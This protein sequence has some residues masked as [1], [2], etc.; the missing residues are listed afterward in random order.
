MKKAGSSWSLVSVNPFYLHKPSPTAEVLD[1]NEMNAYSWISK[2]EPQLSLGQHQEEPDVH[3][4]IVKVLEI[5]F[6]N[7]TLFLKKKA[8]VN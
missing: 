2:N 6:L 5:M 3:L 4:C 1:T 7:S 8:R